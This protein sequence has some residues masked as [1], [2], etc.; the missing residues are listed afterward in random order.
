MALK[1]MGTSTTRFKQGVFVEGQDVHGD[2]NQLVVTGSISLMGLGAQ[3]TISANPTNTEA[4]DGNNWYYLAGDGSAPNNTNYQPRI[5]LSSIPIDGGGSWSDEIYTFFGTPP[6]DIR[7]FS[8]KQGLTGTVTISFLIIGGGDVGSGGTTNDIKLADEPTATS[9]SHGTLGAPN[10]HDFT[11]GAADPY[12]PVKLMYSTDGFTYQSTWVQYGSYEYHSHYGSHPNAGSA[13]ITNSAF[14]RV[15]VTVSGI[16]GTY[17]LGLV[18][19]ITSEH[20]WNAWAIADLSISEGGLSYINFEPEGTW[21]EGEEG[22]GFRNN[23]GIME[24]KDEGFDWK[25]FSSLAVGPQAPD[26]AIQ[27]NNQGELGSGN[28]FYGSNANVGVGDFTN[29]DPTK[30]FSIRGDS[31][32]YGNNAVLRMEDTTFVPTIQTYVGSGSLGSETEL[33]AGDVIFSLDAFGADDSLQIGHPD[34]FFNGQGYRRWSNMKTS[35]KDMTSGSEHEGNIT[36][37]VADNSELEPVLD[38]H[39]WGITIRDQYVNPTTSVALRML[40]NPFAY[41]NFTNTGNTRTGTPITGESGFGLAMREGGMY[42]KEQSDSTWT[43]FSD[44]M[45]VSDADGDTYIDPEET[46]DDDTLRFYA[47][48]NEEMRIDSDRVNIRHD[49]NDGPVM[50]M[51]RVESQIGDVLEDST[52]AEIQMGVS[53]DEAVCNIKAV[54]T[55]DWLAPQVFGDPSQRGTRLEFQTTY[56]DGEGQTYTATRFALDHQLA[57]FGT[58]LEVLGDLSIGAS[59]TIGQNIDVQNNIGVLGTLKSN[60]WSSND[61]PST[62]TNQYQLMAYTDSTTTN[63]STSANQPT[64]RINPSGVDL[65]FVYQDD[66][67]NHTF[68]CRAS[69]GQ[70]FIGSLGGAGPQYS[71]HNASHDHGGLYVESNSPSGATMTV[72]NRDLGHGGDGIGI[73]IGH[74]RWARASDLQNLG[75]RN[76][77]E[78]PQSNNYW[79]KMYGKDRGF[80]FDDFDTGDEYPPDDIFLAGGFRGDSNGGILS[81]GVTFTGTHDSMSTEDISEG[82]IVESTGTLWISSG[83][84]MSLPSVSPSSSSKSK[85]VYGVVGDKEIFSGRAAKVPVGCFGYTINSLGEGK[86]WV[87]NLEGE[88]TNG[89]FITSSPISG[90]GQLQDDDILHSYTVAKLTEAIDWSSITE[91]INHEGVPYKK[92][93]AGCTYHCG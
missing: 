85:K 10:K 61:D 6:N 47:A 22:I 73:V 27:F 52:I 38:V 11:G 82:M 37:G 84:S 1:N 30:L 17:Y 48:G 15:D 45:G 63:Y 9:N 44:L 40:E 5:P 51:T 90:Y 78:E 64:I 81:H 92:Y 66:D 50:R 19:D 13:N 24:Y 20:N 54:A 46:T 35:I 74:G 36:F 65:D 70:T 55:E 7:M 75:Y 60:G 88:P 39:R 67:S 29:A 16:S 80:G 87:T 33:S 3:S 25:Q 41:I 69:D 79:I 31:G 53:V 12:F 62:I 72:V 58:S 68:H 14:T 71:A 18:Q 23:A 26:R 34:N 89:D 42:F 28:F 21:Y 32:G 49:S 77:R 43:R 57:Y 4:M 59:F 8:H 86:V 83:M 91:T 76:W 2:A 93:L 56:G